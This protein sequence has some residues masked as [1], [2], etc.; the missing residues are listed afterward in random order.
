MNVI[1]VYYLLLYIDCEVYCVCYSVLFKIFMYIIYSKGQFCVELYMLFCNVFKSWFSQCSVIVMCLK[2]YYVFYYYMLFYCC[3][4]SMFHCFSMITNMF[5][6]VV[7]LV[8]NWS[9]IVLIIVL[10]LPFSTVSSNW[11]CDCLLYNVY[12]C[13][14]LN[15]CEMFFLNSYIIS[16][17]FSG[18]FYYIFFS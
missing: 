6:L 7:D 11:P 3:D 14:D 1:D 5:I 17:P 15:C 9:M 18:I 10:S 12:Y 2:F 16:N 13:L 8:S 4:Y